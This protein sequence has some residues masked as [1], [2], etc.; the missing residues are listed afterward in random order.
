MDY[1]EYLTIWIAGVKKY[2]EKVPEESTSEAI[3]KLRILYWLDL[4]VKTIFYF[5]IA[6]F[7]CKSLDFGDRYLSK[8]EACN[9]NF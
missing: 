9:P 2:L 4:I 6:F 3:K 8:C 7:F 5:V 1:D